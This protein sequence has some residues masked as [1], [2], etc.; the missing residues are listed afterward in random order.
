MASEEVFDVVVHRHV[1]TSSRPFSAVLDSIFDGISQ[2]Y[3]G[4][5]FGEL[6]GLRTTAWSCC[7][8]GVHRY[9]PE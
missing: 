1:L 2:P 7:G 4:Q 3:I 8:Y 6:D 5:L 9:T